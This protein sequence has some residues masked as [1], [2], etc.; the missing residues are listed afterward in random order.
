MEYTKEYLERLLNHLVSKKLV[1]CWDSQ[2][3]LWTKE[4]VSLALLTV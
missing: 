1:F 3:K 2:G 4:T